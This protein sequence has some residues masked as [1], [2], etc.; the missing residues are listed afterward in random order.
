MTR[1]FVLYDGVLIAAMVVVCVSLSLLKYMGEGIAQAGYW[2]VFL[3]SL[4]VLADSILHYF[5]QN[6]LDALYQLSF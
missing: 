2:T 3:L 5:L 4:R 6:V 1:I